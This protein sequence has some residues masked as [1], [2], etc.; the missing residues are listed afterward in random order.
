MQKLFGYIMQLMKSHTCVILPGM[1]AFVLND[2]A[3]SI[4]YVSGCFIPPTT[5][6]VFN[7]HIAYNDGLLAGAFASAEGISIESAN[8]YIS[9]VV[10]KA[11]RE[12]YE[13]GLFVVGEYGYFSQAQ[14]CLSFTFMK[15]HVESINSFGL[16]KFHFPQIEEGCKSQ[17]AMS[18]E[19]VKVSNLAGSKS[20]STMI[21]GCLAALLL[22]LIFSQPMGN[23]NMV[24]NEMASLSP[25]AIVRQTPLHHNDKV[26]FYVAV[27]QFETE[28]EAQN[29][30]KNVESKYGENA[31]FSLLELDGKLIVACEKKE[32]LSQADSLLSVIRNGEAYSD[33]YVIAIMDK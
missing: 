32:S 18:E 26:G 22:L 30:K 24:Y 16:T 10:K 29:A 27:G 6:L 13:R 1:G 8:A 21:Y 15:M 12:L 31:K 28:I 17:V 19:N 9:D 33:A 23:G 7:P 20:P 2:K 5:E 11:K 14:S 3:A 4:D 25:M